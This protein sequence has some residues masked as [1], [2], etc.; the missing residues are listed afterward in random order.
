MYVICAPNRDPSPS[1]CWISSRVSP[2]TTPISRM[3]AAT[4]AS[5]P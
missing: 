3:P 1:A 2:T 4:I 5:T